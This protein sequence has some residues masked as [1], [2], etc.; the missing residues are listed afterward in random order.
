MTKIFCAL[1]ILLS[2]T[3]VSAQESADKDPIDL[4]AHVGFK[5]LSLGMTSDE[6]DSVVTANSWR[7]KTRLMIDTS[8]MGNRD[9]GVIGCEE[10]VDDSRCYY[11]RELLL[12]YLG[13]Y[14]YSVT[15]M[16]PEV[17]LDDSDL[18]RQ[19]LAIA[20]I[21]LNRKYG[22]PTVSYMDVEEL[23][24]RFLLGADAA[25]LYVWDIR[26]E[27]IT[28]GVARSEFRYRPMIIYVDV[29][30][31]KEKTAVRSIQTDL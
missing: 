27:R 20:Q 29:E 3:V 8:P 5:G 1:T 28:L 6:V 12:G 25:A 10:T 16:G 13:D 19:W 31:E 22:N 9:G 14:L 17:N 21:G 4:S 24:D 26:E 7:Q 2:A 30:R 11:A 18:L 23:T 15:A